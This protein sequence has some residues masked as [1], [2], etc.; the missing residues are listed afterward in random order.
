MQQVGYE[1]IST[2]LWSCGPA[3][4]HRMSLCAWGTKHKHP[5]KSITVAMFQCQQT[6]STQAH[7]TVRIAG[8][9]RHLA[10]CDS[11]HPGTKSVM[12]TCRQGPSKMRGVGARAEPKRRSERA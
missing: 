10:S 1:T 11:I 3:D 7:D 4:V 6:T 12:W 9:K 5:D 2:Q 8:I